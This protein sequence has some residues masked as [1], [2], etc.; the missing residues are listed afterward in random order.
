MTAQGRKTTTGLVRGDRILITD[1]PAKASRRTGGDWHPSRVKIGAT[2]ATVLD[3]QA[4]AG[5]RTRYNIVTD[6]GT[7]LD[8][9]GGQTFLLAPPAS[10]PRP[11]GPTSDATTVLPHTGLRAPHGRLSARNL[12]QRDLGGSRVAFDA[13]LYLDD[14]VSGQIVNAYGTETWFEPVSAS[15]FGAADLVAFVALCRDEDGVAV[16]AE[17]VL[18]ALVDEQEAANTVGRVLEAG[19]TP[20]RLLT[21]IQPAGH[22]HGHVKGLPFGAGAPA[23]RGWWGAIVRALHHKRPLNDGE[24]YQIWTGQAWESLP[25]IDDV[26]SGEHEGGAR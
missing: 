13:V 4:V 12:R 1:D 19:R 17:T 2:A 7:V 10:P 9:S 24:I 21:P 3:K 15:P 25:A 8:L 11:D 6:A 23:R 5:R 22:G 16:T 26:T 18:D 20:I 14:Q